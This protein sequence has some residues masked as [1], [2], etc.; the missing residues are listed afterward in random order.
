MQDLLI[1]VLKGISL[2]VEAAVD[3][4]EIVTRAGRFI[5]RSL[6]ATITNANFHDQR[7]IALIQ[8]GIDLKEKLKGKY[9]VKLGENVHDAAVWFSDSVDEF[10]EKALQVGVHHPV[11]V[12]QLDGQGLGQGL[13]GHGGPFAG[14]DPATGAMASR[15]YFR[16]VRPRVCTTPAASK[17]H[18]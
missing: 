17:R 11:G 8:E 14:A 10:H 13:R 15:S 12:A 4:N 2:Y 3:N 18:T 9:H 5:T 6:F 7:I 1:Y 16:S